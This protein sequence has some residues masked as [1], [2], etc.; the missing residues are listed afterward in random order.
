MNS[1][2]SKLSSSALSFSFGSCFFFG[3]VLFGSFGSRLF[4]LVFCLLFHRLVSLF[5]SRSF[6]GTL[7]SLGSCLGVTALLRFLFLGLLF[8]NGNGPSAMPR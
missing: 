7:S 2:S 4:S 3:L 1:D 6:F 5:V 8:G